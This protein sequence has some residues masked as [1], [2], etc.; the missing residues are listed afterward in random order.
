MQFILDHQLTLTNLNPATRRHL[1]RRLTIQN[2]KY[3]EAERAG[4]YTGGIPTHLEFFQE[5]GDQLSCPR[6]FAEQVYHTLNGQVDIVDRRRVVPAEVR[7]KGKLK[8]FQETAVKDLLAHSDGVLSA[9]TGSGKTVMALSMAAARGQRTLVIVHTRELLA[10]WV[11]RIDQFCGI[12][13]GQIGGGRFDLGEQITVGM[14][15]SLCKRDDIQDQ[16]G[17]VI[18]DECHRCPSKTFIDVVS[19]MGAKHRLGLSATTFRRDGLGR[20]IFLFLGDCHHQ[21][22][23]SMLLDQGHLCHAQVIFH[24]TDF[25][26]LLDGSTEYSAMLSELTRDLDR[27]RQICGDIAGDDTGGIRLVLSDR[28]EHCQELAF[29]LKESHGIRATVLHGGIKASDREAIAQDIQAGKVNVLVCTSQLVGEGYD[30][31]ELESLYLTTPIRF[32][33]RLVQYIGRVLRPSVGKD[34]AVIHDY[35]DIHVSVLEASA[36]ARQA[37]YER[38]EIRTEAAA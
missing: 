18:C 27:N 22:D 32:S 8:P 6:G 20:V 35:V 28:K 26:T 1:K 13:A 17:F 12:Q 2:P 34:Q 16:F 30:L 31:P 7:F 19:R 37:E 36:R 29:I 15:Q 38:Q 4:R 25:D 3:R 14:V 10:Q 24:P 23:K 21:V 5:S 9:G 11:D 33:G